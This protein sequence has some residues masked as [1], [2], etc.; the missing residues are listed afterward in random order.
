MAR[1]P[2]AV[3]GA[4]G[5]VG[6]RFV[7]LLAGHPGFEL[8]AVA[9][10]GRSAGRPY[11]EAVR[12][13]Q[14]SALPEDVARMPVA[15]CEPGAVGDC[16]LVFSALDSSVAGE[17]E[18]AFAAAG[19]LVVSN[20]KNHRLDPDVPLV[21]P[22][23]NPDHV[24]LARTQAGP[25]AILTNPNCSTIGLVLAL[26]PLVD[27]FGVERVHVVTLQA[28]SG[29]GIPGVPSMQAVDNVI[30]YIPGEEEKIEAETR[31]I[32]G[33]LAVMPGDGGAAAGGARVEPSPVVVS[34]ACNRVAVIDG[35][36][37][38][39]SVQLAREAEAGELVE[40]WRSFRAEPQERGLFSAPASPVVYLDEPDA[41]QPRLHRDLGGGMA[42]AVGRL[43]P[44]PL[45]HY[46]FVTLSHNTLRGAA[47][48]ALLLAELAVARGLLDG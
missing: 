22:E 38:C 3:L 15:P 33:P 39:V 19:R 32:L 46:K 5:S 9:A 23:V 37:E 25:G 8:R 12:W 21:V 44:C 42:A 14:A 40:A 43:R 47:G 6:Q 20:S 24:E 36:L 11:G 27:A 31:K 26:K 34:A 2:V 41:P 28:L 48:G 10:S 29:A 16:P 1:I 45:F 35:H 17:V 18:S 7:E 4:T 30:P 13:L